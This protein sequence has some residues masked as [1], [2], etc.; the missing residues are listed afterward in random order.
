MGHR[1]RGG[2]ASG[3]R[4]APIMYLFI[5]KGVWYCSAL[6]FFSSVSCFLKWFQLYAF[7]LRKNSGVVRAPKEVL[8]KLRFF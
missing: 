1:A 7:C 8:Y 4:E 5:L 2:A 3:S 6:C